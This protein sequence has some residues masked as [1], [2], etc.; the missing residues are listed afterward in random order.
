MRVCV[1]G[2]VP[3]GVV[4][5]TPRDLWACSYGGTPSVVADLVRRVRARYSGHINP[6]NE[7][8]MATLYSTLL[9]YLASLRGGS[10]EEAE[11]TV[12]IV[13]VAACS[14]QYSCGVKVEL[15]VLSVQGNVL[16]QP[17][18]EMMHK[19]TAARAQAW[20]NAITSIND[21]V[22]KALA[23]RS[24]NPWLTLGEITLLRIATHLFPAT[25]YRHPVLTPASLVLG[26]CLSQC[27]LATPGDVAAGLATA[28]LL[29]EFTNEAGRVAP[30]GMCVRALMPGT[31]AMILTIR[32]PPLCSHVSAAG[33]AVRCGRAEASEEGGGVG[34]CPGAVE[35][36]RTS[37]PAVAA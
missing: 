30:E 9:H 36:S 20:S 32:V 5:L 19:H 34:V 10:V 2:C 18:H 11:R 21:R 15:M 16:L 26:R 24:S 14:S 28:A 37:A 22:A 12:S 17:L 3:W 1:C 31:D 29:I 6:D 33:R 23:G 25:D 13:R 8:N 7:A 27:P 4:R 35:F